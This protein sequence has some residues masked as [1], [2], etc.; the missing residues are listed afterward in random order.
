MRPN[1]S[2]IISYRQVFSG[3]IRNKTHLPAIYNRGGAS[4]GPYT[5]AGLHS[6]EALTTRYPPRCGCHAVPQDVLFGCEL[7]S[8]LVL[9]K[10]TLEGSNNT[11]CNTS[12]VLAAHTRCREGRPTNL[13][14]RP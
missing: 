6:V 5:K 2:L 10:L 13:V 14:R 9:P 3:H 7:S 12:I 8:S 1:I 4:H 11:P